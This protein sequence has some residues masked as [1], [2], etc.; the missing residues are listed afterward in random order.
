MRRCRSVS[1]SLVFSTLTMMSSMFAKA[2]MTVRDVKLLIFVLVCVQISVL[3]TKTQL[4]QRIRRTIGKSMMTC[5]SYIKAHSAKSL[6]KGRWQVSAHGSG[7][8]APEGVLAV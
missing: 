7:K 5:G 4:H 1:I 2:A 6:G 8:T 3:L